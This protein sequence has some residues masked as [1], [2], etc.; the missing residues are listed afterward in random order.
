MDRE[1]SRPPGSSPDPGTA[2]RQRPAPARSF[3]SPCPLHFQL[4][5]EKPPRSNSR[6]ARRS[7]RERKGEPEIISQAQDG[8]TAGLSRRTGPRRQPAVGKLSARTRWS[9]PS[10]DFSPGCSFFV[11]ARLVGSLRVGA[12]VEGAAGES[13]PGSPHLS[14]PPDSPPSPSPPAPHTWPGQDSSTHRQRADPHKVSGRAERAP[15][16]LWRKVAGDSPG[17]WKR[18]RQRQ[19][20]GVGSPRQERRGHYSPQTSGTE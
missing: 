14:A 10:S 12:K 6:S 8:G 7:T 1:G 13:S 19:V 5:P 11:S 18:R 4:C 17:R 20:L 15:V 3:A 16:R 2:P 9:L